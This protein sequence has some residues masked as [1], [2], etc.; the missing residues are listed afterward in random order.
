MSVEPFGASNFEAAATQTFGESVDQTG[1]VA[2]NL[3]W[4]QAAGNTWTLGVSSGSTVQGV[5]GYEPM[6]TTTYPVTFT[7]SGLPSGTAWSVALSGA[8]GSGVAPGSI[9]FN[10]ANGTYSFTVGSVAG[11]TASPSSGS[12]AVNGGAVNEAIAFTPSSVTT[13]AVA[14]TESGLPTGTS[15]SV[16]LNGVLQSS[17]TRTITF[18]EPNGTYAYAISPISGYSTTYNG[19]VKVDGTGSTV[20]VAFTA[21]TYGLTFSEAGLPTGTNWSVTLNGDTEFSTTPTIAFTQPNGTYSF[22]V[23]SVS[24]YHVSPSSGNVTVSGAAVTESITFSPRVATTYAVTFTESG[25][26]SG[27]AWS[28]ALSGAGGSGVAPGSIQF[29]EANGTYSFTVGSVAGYTAS[30]SSGSVTVNGASVNESI[31]FTPSVAATYAVTFTESG[32]PTGTSWSVTLSG[33]L[34][35]SSTSTITFQ[36][37]NGTY[38][39]SAGSVSGYNVAPSTGN[40]RVSGAPVTQALTFSATSSSTSS[41]GFLGLPGNTG[42]YVLIGVVIVVIAGAAV[43]LARRARGK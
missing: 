27:T 8:G 39:F 26:P 21:T 30:P 1:E 11:Y 31:T 16:T 38:A 12:V 13:Y 33:V 9:A 43:A 15:W 23:A 36:E 2:A 10:E 18:Q 41:A 4:S 29:N 14:F 25:L 20:A 32:L 17:S 42:Y 3:G 22:T 34:Q 19:Q 5:I 24:G 6:S 35:S 40:L 37:P 28:V 7:E